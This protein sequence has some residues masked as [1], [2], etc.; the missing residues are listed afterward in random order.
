MINPQMRCKRSLLAQGRARRPYSLVTAWRPAW[1]QWHRSLMKLSDGALLPTHALVNQKG[2][3]LAARG[4]LG[5]AV[6]RIALATRY[7]LAHD[8]VP[9]WTSEP[10]R[11]KGLLR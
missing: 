2:L 9:R 1:V 4:G 5:R 11:Q 8:V 3:D 7:A 6:M 10:A